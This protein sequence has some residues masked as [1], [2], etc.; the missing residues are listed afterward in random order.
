MCGITGVI[1][2]SGTPRPVVAADVLDRMT[3]VMRHRGPNDRGT[4]VADGVALGVRRLSVIDVVDGHQ[5]FANED[6]TIFAIQNGELFNHDRLRRELRERGHVFRS[7]CDTEILPHLYEQYGLDCASSL[8]GMFA[9][10]VWDER[11]R[12]A[13][14][15][16]DRLGVKPLYYAE[17]GDLLVFG[18]ELKA[19]LASGLVSE[20][21]DW[22]AVDAYLQLG[23]IPAP[24]TPFA[25][26]SKLPPGCRLV[27]EH[28]RLTQERWW[29]FPEPETRAGA[30][31]LAEDAR[32][33]LE[34]L[35]DS[36]RLRLMSD[37]PL[38]VMLSGGLDSSLLAA[39]TARHTKGAVQTFSVGFAED[40]RSELDD[41]RRVAAAI[42]AEHHEL[43]LSFADDPVDFEEVLWFL[44]EPIADLSTLGFHAL[45]RLASRHVT[46]ALCGQGPDEL[47][48]GYAKHRAAS[49][50]RAASGV[51]DWARRGIASTARLGGPR[52]ARI[53]S[54][55]GAPTERLLAMSRI[56]DAE[57]RRSLVRG[58][59]ADLDGG[60][61][62]RLI[63]RVAP[64][65][66]DPLAETLFMDGQLALVDDML[67]FTDRMSMAHSL[68]VRVPYLDYRL[69]EQ[70]ARIPSAH[71]VRGS[72]TKLVLKEAARGIVPD[73]I[74]DKRK[75]GFFSQATNAWLERRLTATMGTYLLDP[76]AKSAAFLDRG[77]V[78]RLIRSHSATTEKQGSRLLLAIFM[79]EVWLS[80]SSRS[81]PAP[82]TAAASV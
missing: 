48:G 28:G 49:L 5:P 23:F 7:R 82:A 18:S 40:Q 76:A 46:V 54:T 6:E 29:A 73:A 41:A 43:R 25:A 45:S 34:L 66:A 11:R 78:E 13:L 70:S 58:P 19:L 65:A 20:E 64:P 3:D 30:R 60:S 37:V 55:A 56:S 63:A 4:Y 53:A 36:V 27:A 10:A 1:Q 9:F 2:I 42:G 50:L 69:V 8:N 15:V 71:K 74:V 72:T 31:N 14:V 21:L 59:L 79:L 62:S 61:A 12:R 39:L 22:E 33:L 75:I 77:S 67:H 52:L 17:V 32:E 38:G 68:E 81:A 57:L 80:I 16:R 44:D 26:V 24:R 51:P 35:E 47:Y